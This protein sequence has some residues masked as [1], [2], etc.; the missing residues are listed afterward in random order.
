MA[1][2][3]QDNWRKINCLLFAAKKARRQ[4]KMQIAVYSKKSF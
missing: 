2:I 4:F 1:L 3:E